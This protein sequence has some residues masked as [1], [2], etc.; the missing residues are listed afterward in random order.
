MIDEVAD[1]RDNSFT[2]SVKA[3]EA[4]VEWFTDGFTESDRNIGDFDG[5]DVRTFSSPD[6]R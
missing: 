2:P 1:L 4:A 3:L 5:D 6:R